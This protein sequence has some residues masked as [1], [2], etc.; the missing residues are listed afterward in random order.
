[1][2]EPIPPSADLERALVLGRRLRWAGG[3]RHVARGAKTQLRH[4]TA[5][6]MI[7]SM[8]AA[9]TEGMGLA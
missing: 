9:A 2:S 6:G 3:R 1:M 4:E 5:L 8:A 7:S